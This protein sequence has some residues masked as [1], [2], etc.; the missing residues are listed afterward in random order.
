MGIHVNS[1]TAASAAPDFSIKRGL[2]SPGASV[3]ALRTACLS[4][5]RARLYQR[6]RCVLTDNPQ[7]THFTV[8]H[9]VK[10]L[11]ADGA[12]APLSL[13]AAAG[14]VGMPDAMELSGAVTSAL[15]AGL[16]VGSRNVH[17]P[18]SL[19]RRRI[20]RT[21]LALL[22][23][24]VTGML[25][26]AEGVLRERWSWMFHPLMGGALGLILFLLGIVS[27]TPVIGG[28]VQHAAS[29]FF[30]AVGI[31]E[32]DG[33]AVMIGALAGIACLALAALSIASGRKLWAKVKAWLLRCARKLHLEAFARML[34]RCCDGLGE[35]VRL[36]WSGLLLMMLSPVAEISHRPRADGSPISLLRQRACRARSAAE[37][38]Y[39]QSTC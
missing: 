4:H 3:A 7:T 39:K 1:M 28:G 32:R 31:A 38:A 10:A 17:L 26:K 19:L 37:H 20:P 25:E 36:R 14:V 2:R 34:D 22:I 24:A 12:S 6:L 18:R 29:A 30:I 13:F 16:A 23:H 9:I 15:G 5:D 8:H 27:M 35:L 21:S 33:L 11:S